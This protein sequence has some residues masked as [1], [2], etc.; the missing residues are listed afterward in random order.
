M[1]T[2]RALV[3]AGWLAAV[4]CFAGEQAPYVPARADIVL[5][6][7]PSISDPRVRAFTGLRAAL[8]RNP[9]DQGQAVK[10]SEAYLDYGRDTGDARYLGRAAAVIAPWMGLSPPPIPVLLVHATILQSKHYFAAARA[11]LRAILRRQPDNA[12]AWLTLAT[13]A[14]VQGDM[15]VARSACAHLLDSSDPLLPGACLA[16]LNAVD[17][18]AASAYHLLSLL[19]P[20]ARAEP[21]AVRSWIQGILADSA[22]YLG[23]DAAADRHFRSALQLA[24]G[25]NFLLADYADFLLDEKRPRAALELVKDYSQSDTS[26]LRQV[27]AEAA[28]GS[29]RAAAD[30]AQ[31]ARRFAALE[32]RGSRTYRREQAG[33]VLYL[34][35]DPSRALELAQEN[36]TVQ[37]APEDMRV[38][39]EAALAAGKLPAAQ[40]VLDLLAKSHLEYSLVAGLAARVRTE[41]ARQAPTLPP[42]RA[43]SAASAA[44]AGRDAP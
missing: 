26:F 30:T 42:I 3:L 21:V 20:Q 29:P 7:V 39:L 2:Y 4:P 41:L 25:D 14:Q 31:M 24:P 1:M 13:V 9:A 6:T 43:V 23:E 12:Q 17:G 15:G 32:I 34:E 19:W 8:A 11:Q 16:S 33:F 28:L 36:W 38:L 18:H 5:Q 27:Y 35:H 44:A 40:P 37:R 10:L 22:K